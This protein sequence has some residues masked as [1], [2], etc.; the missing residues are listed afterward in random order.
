MQDVK[1]FLEEYF[2]LEHEARLATLDDTITFK[3]H[4]DKYDHRL[5]EYWGAARTAINHDIEDLRETMDVTEELLETWRAG[6]TKRIVFQIEAYEN[7]VFGEELKEKFPNVATIYRCIIS[8]YMTLAMS[9]K[10]F[11]ETF[12]V[13]EHE[14]KW[15]IIYREAFIQKSWRPQDDWTKGHVLD[16]GTLVK[17]E[18]YVAPE[19]E[20]SLKLYKRSQEMVKG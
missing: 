4:R 15:K 18:S 13:I 8:S 3:E 11:S 7:P 20:V 19:E 1:S 10:S 14:G 2:E 16:F 6:F 5:A 9:E 17:V 12:S